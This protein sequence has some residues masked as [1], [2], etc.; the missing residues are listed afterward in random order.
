MW[1]R[2]AGLGFEELAADTA[3]FEFGLDGSALLLVST[4]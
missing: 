3:V 1:T 2:R 4:V